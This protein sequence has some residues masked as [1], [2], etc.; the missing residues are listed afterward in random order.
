MGDLRILTLRQVQPDIA[1]A[2]RFAGYQE[3]N[4]EKGQQLCQQ[5]LPLLRRSLQP[6]AALSFSGDKLYVILTLGKGVS[7]QLARYEAEQQ[8]PEAMLFSALA[9]TCL[10]ALEKQLQP[11]LRLI[12][13]QKKVGIACRHEPGSDVPLSWQKKAVEETN[14]PRTVGVTINDA[15]A[16]SPAKS[17]SLVFQLTDDMNVFS[18]AH[19]C[20]QCPNTDCPGRQTVKT[21]ERPLTCPPHTAV[22]AYLQQQQIPL[23]L[24]CGGKGICGKCRIRVLRGSLPVTAA[25]KNCFS[26]AQLKDGWRLACQAVTGEESIEIAV[27]AGEKEFTALSLDDN[28]EKEAAQVPVI[29]ETHTYGAAVDIG[30]TTL[31]V[32]L[33]DLTAKKVLATKTAV[34]SQRAFGADV[35]SRIQAANGGQAAALRQAVRSDLLSLLRQFFTA[36]PGIQKHFSQ[37][38]IAA[39]TT[40]LHLLM[41]WSCKGLGS[42]PFQ[43]VSLGGDTYPLA[44]VLGEDL[45]LA[46]C[47]V[48]LL[49]GMTTYVGA[50]ITAG[51]YECQLT[52]QEELSLLLDLGTNGEMALGNSRQLLIASAPAGPALEGGKITWGTGSVPGAICS[53]SLSDGH[54]RVQ[55]IEE[56]PPVG[57]CGTGIIEAMAML[58]QNGLVDT[59]GKLQAPYF[60][61]GLPLALTAQGKTIMLNQTDIREIQMAKSAIRAGVEALLKKGNYTYEQIRHVYLAGGFGYY[62]KP[63]AAAAIGLLPAEWVPRTRAVGNTSLKGAVSLLLGQTDAASLKQLAGRAKEVVLGNDPVFQQLYIAYLNF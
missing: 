5:L 11:R 12:C 55:T 48:T 25:D 53:V 42:W 7:W 8:Y 1:Q 18:A 22:H 36:Y 56:K 47:Q 43:P 45:G 61:Q 26:A 24:P 6:K 17:M 4:Q 30:T 38:T 3:K 13:Q 2:L 58:V 10:F 28:K 54:P 46:D 16:L 62:L 44:R 15:L 52:Q 50:D 14:A 40:M 57:L 51:L 23:A 33:A 37:L 19:D 9:D 27:P 29:D 39:N 34:N 20:R 59:T 21:E 35:I 60:P 49:P 32:A 41:G 63:A 31:A